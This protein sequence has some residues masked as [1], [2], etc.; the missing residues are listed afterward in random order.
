MLEI[1]KKILGELRVFLRQSA[2]IPEK[3][4]QKPTDFTRKRKFPFDFLS[5]FL[6]KLLKKSTDWAER[7][8]QKWG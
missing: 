2:K 5:K 3:Y 8:F 6:S 1:S 7:F 4:R